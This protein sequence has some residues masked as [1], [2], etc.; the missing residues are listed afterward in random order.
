LFEAL[1]DIVLLGGE[2]GF[3]QRG[4][5]GGVLFQKGVDGLAGLGDGGEEGGDVL[6][7]GL[8][9]GKE[10]GGFQ[11]EEMAE[12]GGGIGERLVGAVDFSEIG[13]GAGDI[14]M[15]PP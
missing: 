1:L 6:G 15:M 9:A 4:C 3:C 13:G 12:A 5:G 14:G 2:E 11:I 10:A 7:D 8:G